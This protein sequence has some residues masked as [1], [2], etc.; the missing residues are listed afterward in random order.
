MSKIY[1]AIKALHLSTRTPYKESL[2]QIKHTGHKEL[3]QTTVA[4]QKHD[5]TNHNNLYDTIIAGWRVHK[6]LTA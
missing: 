1:C 3:L 4:E 6:T 2:W 5:E